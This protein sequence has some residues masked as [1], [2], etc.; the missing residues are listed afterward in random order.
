MKPLEEFEKLK[1]RFVG[2]LGRDQELKSLNR[3]IFLKLSTLRYSY[4]FTWLGA[5]IIQ[6][7]ADILALQEI[8][9]R[10][11]PDAILETGIAH[12]GSLI[13]YSSML[14]LMG[15]DG[16]VVGV[17]I[18]I[19]SHNREIIEAHPMRSHIR[20]IEGS[21]V[22]PETVAQVKALLGDR[23]R[24]LVILDSNHTKD[25][26]AAEI[27]AYEGLVSRG[28]YLIVLDTV[29]DDMPKEFSADRPWGPKFGPKAAVHEFLARNDRFEIDSEF[30]DKLV[31]SVAP[32]GYLRC[33]KD[34]S[35]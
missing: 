14:H 23:K 31:L 4:H 3:E 20:L 1:C 15:G 13:F 32:D 25:H 30:N 19:R 17:D 22:A 35:A 34:R 9:W 11:R 2:E 12:G 6:F 24:I 18:D 16:F 33:I 21:S 29:V 28:S 8:V 5:P 10:V 26:V 27:A 7:P